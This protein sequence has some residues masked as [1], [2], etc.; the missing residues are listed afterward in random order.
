MSSTGTGTG[1]G[2]PAV[3]M[4]EIRLAGACDASPSWHEVRRRV[5]AW[6]AAPPRPPWAAGWTLVVRH[7][8]PAD[9]RALL[10]DGEAE[11]PS[12]CWA[13]FV[14]GDDLCVTVAVPADAEEHVTN[15]PGTAAM[16]I[17]LLCVVADPSDF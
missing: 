11:D 3:G 6:F 4:V 10:E 8:T 1:A 9:D 15:A 17:E 5:G 13:V 16:L 12:S 7:K 14:E 2:T